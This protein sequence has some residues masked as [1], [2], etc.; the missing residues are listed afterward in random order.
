MGHGCP[1]CKTW[2]EDIVIVDF[3]IED[4]LMVIEIKGEVHDKRKQGLKDIKREKALL[5]RGYVVVSI[6]NKQVMELWN[7]FKKRPV[8]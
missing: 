6:S 2:A 8:I 3:L 1:I 4:P 5:M 7:H